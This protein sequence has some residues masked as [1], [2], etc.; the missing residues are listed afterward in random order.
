MDNELIT[1]EDLSLSLLRRLADA[2]LAERDKLHARQRSGRGFDDGDLWGLYHT[3]AEFIHPRLVA[4]R[5]MET[6]SYPG[7]MDE[8]TWDD[9]LDKMI[10]AFSLIVADDA[11]LEDDEVIDEGLRL[12]GEYYMGLWD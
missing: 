4:F 2:E 12:F 6:I 9:I 5:A 11:S 7:N 10:A 1:P 8:S 3:L